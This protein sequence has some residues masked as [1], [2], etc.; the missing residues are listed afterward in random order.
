MAA[1]PS[2]NAEPAPEPAPE[3][4][5]PGHARPRRRDTALLRAIAVF[6]FLKAA[7]L[8]AVSVGIFRTMHQD[9]GMKL[10]RFISA[11]R[12]DPGNRHIEMLLARISNLSPEQVKKLGVVGLIY[13]GLFLVEGT[14]LWLQRRWGEW[15]TV[16]ITGLLIPVE[17]YEIHRHPSVVK[18]LVLV[19]NA[20]VVWYLIHRIRTGDKRLAEL[21]K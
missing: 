20:A 21:K 9:L 13:A 12:L 16:L 2:F 18:A 14:G 6:K 5:E 4:R 11:M 1:M 17:G 15:A 10:E 19:V 8:I 7:S 3:G